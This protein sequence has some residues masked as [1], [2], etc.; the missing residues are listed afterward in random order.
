LS[1]CGGGVDAMFVYLLLPPKSSHLL[2]TGKWDLDPG[3]CVASMIHGYA[4]YIYGIYGSDTT[5]LWTRPSRK[6]TGNSAVIWEV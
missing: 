2:A 1:C 5:I 4:A 3:C 6:S